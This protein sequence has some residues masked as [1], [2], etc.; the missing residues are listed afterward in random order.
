[1]TYPCEK[2]SA[3]WVV[4]RVNPRERLHTPDDSGYHEN[5]MPVGEVD[6]VYQDGELPC[7]FHINLDLAL[8]SLVSDT[9]NVTL[10]KQRKQTL[11]KTKKRNILNILYISYYVIYIYYIVLFIF[12]I[13]F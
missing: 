12:Y 13:I 11:R 2:L 7:S 5:Q 9:N 10:P 4:Y 3:W 1:M 6:K 8:N